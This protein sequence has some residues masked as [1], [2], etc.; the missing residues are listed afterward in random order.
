MIK[1]GAILHEL[2]LLVSLSMRVG[3]RNLA[4]AIELIFLGTGSAYPSP[5]RGASCI[6]LRTG[7]IT[8]FVVLCFTHTPPP[9]VL[10]YSEVGG[11][12]LFD[13]G[14]GS[15][16]QIMRSTVRPGRITK[17]FITH[18]HGDHVRVGN[19]TIDWDC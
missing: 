9:T 3:T 19:N 17:I 10:I 2:P 11:C 14:E 13:C 16:I 4:M 5:S 6:A 18:L 12:W 8:S 1:G 15:Q 7:K